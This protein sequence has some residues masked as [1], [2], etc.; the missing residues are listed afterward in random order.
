MKKIIKSDR[1][2]F[3]GL[4]DICAFDK[5]KM[6]QSEHWPLECVMFCDFPADR[7]EGEWKVEGRWKN[8]R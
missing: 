6:N 2:E 8:E 7:W 1:C 3:C 5:V 4:K